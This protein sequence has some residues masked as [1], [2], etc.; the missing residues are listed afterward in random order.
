MKK[1]ISIL[2]LVVM[3][4]CSLSLFAG[5]QGEEGV[6]GQE[7]PTAIKWYVVG[8]MQPQDWLDV[9]EVLDE[10]SIQDINMTLDLKVVPWGDFENKMAVVVASGEEYDLTFTSNWMFDFATFAGLDAFLPLDG[11][12]DEFGNDYTSYVPEAIRSA[13]KVKGDSY[14]MINYQIST[15][16]ENKMIP[17]DLANAAGFDPFN[18]YK[19]EDFEPFFE[20]ISDN[21]PEIYCWSQFASG[22]NFDYHYLYYGIEAVAGLHVPGAIMIDDSSL[23]VINQFETQEFED[24]CKL[25]EKWNVLGYVKSDQI[26]IEDGA[27]LSDVGLVGV[28][29]HNRFAYNYSDDG[30]IIRPY[31]HNDLAYYREPFPSDSTPFLQTGSIQGTMTAVSQTSTHPEKAVEFFNYLYKDK[32]YLNT[33]NYGIEGVHWNEVPELNDQI[34]LTDKGNNYPLHLITWQLGPGNIEASCW[35][36]E[37]RYSKDNWKVLNETAIPS[38]M[39]GFVF[40]TSN[41]L[42]ELTGIASVI[43]EYYLALNLGMGDADKNLAKFR[44]QLKKAGADSVITEMQ[45]QLDEWKAFK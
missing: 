24:Y 10:R 42:T 33:L 27:S 45:H 18:M 12:I 4:A 39:L 8:S 14:A 25:M 40:D 41:V 44:T 1:R 34:L 22:Y 32:D 19:L 11:Y 20:W 23:T 17:Y 37:N 6:N 7:K 43:D 36:V 16:Q 21:K 30:E 3:M 26:S 13:T 28:I 5:A 31:M 35:K 2:F 15:L 9:K 38:P 29:S